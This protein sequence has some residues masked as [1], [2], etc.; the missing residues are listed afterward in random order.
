M[1]LNVKTEVRVM[2]SSCFELDSFANL[3][4]GQAVQDSG[5][6]ESEAAAEASHVAGKV[7]GA[8]QGAAQAVRGAVSGVG[9]LSL[10]LISFSSPP[11]RPSSTKPQ[12]SK[13]PFTPHP[14]TLYPFFCLLLTRPPPPHI[15]ATHTG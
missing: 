5:V 15:Q 4:V 9:L 11:I 1:L 12:L 8:A 13:T 7:T 3:W 2:I 10:Q 6:M 14:Q